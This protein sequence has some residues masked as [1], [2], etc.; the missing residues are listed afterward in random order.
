MSQLVSSLRYR[1]K[2]LAQFLLSS[3][4]YISF[5]ALASFWQTGLWLVLAP[6]LAYTVFLFFSSMALYLLHR[7]LST[8]RQV[9][10]EQW[11]FRLFARSMPDI[12]WLLPLSALLAFCA[13]FFLSWQSWYILSV[14]V[15]LSL[16]YVLPLFRAGRR[17]RDFPQ[18]KAPWLAC[19]WSALTISPYLSEYEQQRISWGSSEL[20]LLFL[21]RAVFVYSLILILDWR[22]RQLD[23]S[24]QVATLSNSLERGTWLWV[25]ALLLLLWFGLSAL[26]YP[27]LLLL[28]SLATGFLALFLAFY[29]S[30][31]KEVHE[32]IYSFGV[33]GLLLLQALFFALY[34]LL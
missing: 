31:R 2:A 3:Q 10:P 25:L 24:Q 32:Y 27:P 11:R 18:L 26:L 17:G 33:D 7:Y 22:D 28:L 12:L 19:T 5:C 14:L 15:F 34:R 29:V 9:L 6:P 20:W 4:I 21:E 13:A 8:V 16:L 1:L 23:A 30:A